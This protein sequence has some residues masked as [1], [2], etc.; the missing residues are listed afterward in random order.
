MLRY[1]RNTRRRAEER[2]C[3]REVREKRQADLRVQS[4]ER[5]QRERRIAAGTLV[6]RQRTFVECVKK[7]R[8][9]AETDIYNGEEEGGSGE[10]GVIVDGTRGSNSRPIPV[11]HCVHP[12]VFAF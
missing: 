4:R 3:A 6:V 12:A 11:V 7:R 9:I 8:V 10:A 2:V 1:Y 5:E